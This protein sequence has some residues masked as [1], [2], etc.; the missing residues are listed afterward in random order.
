MAYTVDFT[1]SAKTAIT[2]ANG[3][4]N[5]TT[6]VGLVGQ[7]YSSFGEVIAETT[8][9]LL[10]NFANNTAPLSMVE[11]QIWYDNSANQLKYYDD[12]SAGNWKP[13]ASMTY[14]SSAP[15]SAG[16]Q[17]GHFWLDSDNG[18]LYVYYNGAWKKISDATLGITAT[19][20]E[21]N[22][23]SGVTWSPSDFN[24]LTPSVTQL[25]YLVSTTSD[26]QV[27][28]NSK[29]EVNTDLTAILSLTS[30]PNKI[31]MYTG[32]GTAT[33]IDFIDE[34]DLASD[35]PTAVPSQQSVKAYASDTAQ[36][37][38]NSIALGVG[39]TWTEF[40]NGTERA[41]DIAYENDT[42]RPIVVSASFN[43]SS[44]AATFKLADSETGTYIN[45][46]RLLDDGVTFTYIIPAG[47][48]YKVTGVDALQNWVE[49]R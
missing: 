29:Q 10:E 47:K 45:L 44:G 7:G 11:G 39:Q 26:V 13:L 2:V 33:L 20:A 49:L 15:A 34:D 25:N 22:L 24:T 30:A 16:E 31:P 19:T 28:L 35:S 41:A 4:V 43:N 17:N 3:S 27:Q 14:A 36:T 12:N 38:T 5:T 40:N 46:G 48:W 1:D 8:L 6:S 18:F 32:T 23:L 42:G 37:Y 9:H 21:I